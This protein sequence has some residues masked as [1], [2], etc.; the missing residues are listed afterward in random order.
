MRCARRPTKLRPVLPRATAVAAAMVVTLSTVW[1]WS[2]V[3]RAQTVTQCLWSP[4]TVSKGLGSLENLA[5]DGTGGL[6]LSR[7]DNGIGAIYR[8]F[9]D[10]GGE[11]V[12]PEVDA[13]GSITVQDTNAY[14]TT[15]NSFLSGFFGSKD[16]TIDRIDLT[17]SSVSP[18]ATGLTM[19]NGMVRLPDGSFIVSRNLGLVTGLTKVSSD[20][21]V[22]SPWASSLT[23]TNGLTYDPS[24]NMV[25]TS[26]DLHPVTTLALI[27]VADP[28]RVRRINLGLFGLFGFPDDL[29]TGPDGL[30]YLAMDGGN[31]VRIDPDGMSACN[32]ARFRF[33]STSVRFGR[34]PGW[35]P[36]SLYGTTLG[37]DVYR[38]TPPAG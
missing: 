28:S 16:G 19:P 27:D 15:G 26:L 5:F 35:D 3:A 20:G 22:K 37:G 30:I 8:L 34:G 4:S 17:T 29:T 36:N 6:L 11:T 38:L 14:I 21:A 1:P 13:P 31:V 7:T 9:P 10:G 18:V 2:T 33:G 23:L 25:I 24:R 12:V 32:V